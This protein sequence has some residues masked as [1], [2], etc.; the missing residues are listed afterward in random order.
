M[1]K[2]LVTLYPSDTPGVAMPVLERVRLPAALAQQLFPVSCGSEHK[3]E[4]SEK[5][6]AIEAAK[7]DGQDGTKEEETKPPVSYHLM[8]LILI[9]LIAI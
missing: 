9:S 4:E 2:A 3:D 1:S 5:L 8:R 6:L 7:K